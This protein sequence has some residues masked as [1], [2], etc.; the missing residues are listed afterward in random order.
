[1]F[2]KEETEESIATFKKA[3]FGEPLEYQIEKNRFNKM[4]K[5]SGQLVGGNLSILYSL[6]GSEILPNLRNA[7]LFFEDLDEYLYHIDRMMMNLKHNKYFEGLSGLIVGGM[8]SMHDNAIPFG[9]NAKEII[10]IIMYKLI[11]VI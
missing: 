1:M 11:I 6:T 3:L 2:N 7:I 4:G 5:A 10:I 9:K 8:T